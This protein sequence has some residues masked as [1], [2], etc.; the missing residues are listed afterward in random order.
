[1]VVC[2]LSVRTDSR[3]IQ[4]LS[5]FRFGFRFYGAAF[6]YGSC[7]LLRITQVDAQ[8]T[9]S[10]LRNI[11]SDISGSFSKAQCSVAAT[12]CDRGVLGFCI[13]D[14]ITAIVVEV[15]AGMVIQFTG[16]VNP[17]GDCSGC[18][19]IECSGPFPAGTVECHGGIDVSAD[20]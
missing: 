15:G 7:P 10:C 5:F 11:D 2:P 8:C 1:M 17:D 12:E 6:L 9:F 19:R 18:I 20:I 4:I 3:Q 13:V 14:V 16:S